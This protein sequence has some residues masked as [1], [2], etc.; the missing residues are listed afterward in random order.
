MGDTAELLNG[1]M[2]LL[3]GQWPYR[4]FF[5]ILPPG[6]VVFPAALLATGL[7]VHWVLYANAVCSVLIGLEAFLL[8]RRVFEADLPAA[9]VAWLVFFAGPTYHHQGFQYIHLYLLFALASVHAAW[10]YFESRRPLWLCV[11]G[12]LAGLGLTFRFYYALAAVLATLIVL[13]YAR[14]R[15]GFKTRAVW[16]YLVGLTLV[17]GLVCLAFFPVFPQMTSQVLFDSIDHG[18]TALPGNLARNLLVVESPEQRGLIARLLDDATGPWQMLL[19]SSQFLEQWFLRAL[20]LLMIVVVPSFL[21]GVWRT[22]PLSPR[23]LPLSILA[24]WGAMMMFR[25]LAEGML[26]KVSNASAPLFFLLT[27]TLLQSARDWRTTRRRRSAALALTVLLFIVGIGQH[28]LRVSWVQFERWQSNRYDLRAPNGLLRLGSSLGDRNLR[29]LIARLDAHLSE[30][31][32][33]FATSWF[34]PPLNALFRVPNPSSYDSLI[35]PV[36]RPSPEKEDRIC[37]ELLRYRT[38]V[39]HQPGSRLA[40]QPLEERLPRLMRCIE[41]NSVLVEAVGPFR[42]LRMEL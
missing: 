42:I 36:L 21:L 8:G 35:D 20:M 40:K 4:D 1:G 34:V 10:R 5:L 28:A 27:H 16:A 25:G 12:I 15:G 24:L 37:R 23:L 9:V 6:E 7:G 11:A 19:L 33:L 22:D 41:E 26:P 18:F 17:L 2:R 31:D 29:T 32:R 14:R 13:G 39:V 3:F 30:E 38:V